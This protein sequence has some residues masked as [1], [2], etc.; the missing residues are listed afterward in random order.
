[1]IA[2]LVIGAIIGSFAISL[3]RQTILAMTEGTLSCEGNGD[4]IIN[5]AGED[6][7]V[8]GMPALSSHTNY[9]E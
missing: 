4:V 2:R 8:S 7:A 1:V 9:L 5:V 6:Y 3:F